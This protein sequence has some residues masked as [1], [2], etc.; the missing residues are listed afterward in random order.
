MHEEVL[1][2]M[3]AIL[4]CNAPLIKMDLRSHQLPSKPTDPTRVVDLEDVELRLMLV[5]EV[6]S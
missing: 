5:V 2:T 3:L 1:V 6:V 4:Y